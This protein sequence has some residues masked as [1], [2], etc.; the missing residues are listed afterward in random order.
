[1]P[2][3]YGD[4]E[5]VVAGVLRG[6]P[7]IATFEPLSVGT[8]LVGYAK[9]A[10]WLVVQRTGGAPTLWRQLDNPQL[11]IAAYAEDQGAA[12][13]LAVAAR[14]AIFAARGSSGDG[15]ELYDVSEDEGLTWSPDER[16]PSIARYV[17][18]LVLVTRQVTT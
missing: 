5:N 18:K 17:F 11:R 13:D 8:N 12:F 10:R 2:A 7:V 15:I 6:S 4:I 3:V 9:P 16:D 1:M 14:D